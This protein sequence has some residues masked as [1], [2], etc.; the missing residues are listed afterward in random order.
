VVIHQEVVIDSG[1]IDLGE[2]D[3]RSGRS[4]QDEGQGYASSGQ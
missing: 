4:E 3:R 2:L 1:R